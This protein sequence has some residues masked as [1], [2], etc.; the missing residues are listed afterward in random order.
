MVAEPFFVSREDLPFITA[1]QVRNVYMCERDEETGEP[2]IGK[3]LATVEDQL[4]A[5]WEILGADRKQCDRLWIEF[6]NT[7]MQKVPNRDEWVRRFDAI[8]GR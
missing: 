3:T 6:C 2:I 5:K 8:M 4:R 7:M 1:S